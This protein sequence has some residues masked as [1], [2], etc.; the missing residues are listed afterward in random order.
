M[1]INKSQALRFEINKVQNS[2]EFR[3]IERYI[4]DFIKTYSFFSLDRNEAILS[5]LAQFEL[6]RRGSSIFS[7]RDSQLRGVDS[8]H[9]ISSRNTLFSMAL[10]RALNFVFDL[11]SSEELPITN[12]LYLN[13]FSDYKKIIK[14]PEI[15]ILMTEYV[16]FEYGC[17]MYSRGY[18]DISIQ[19]NNVKFVPK[20]TDFYNAISF[21]SLRYNTQIEKSTFDHAFEK[22]L[23]LQSENSNVINKINKILHYWLHKTGFL[24]L[25]FRIPDSNIPALIS[26][27]CGAIESYK[28]ISIN[29]NL[30]K[31]SL[32]DFRKFWFYLDI[33]CSLIIYYLDPLIWE[34]IQYPL[35]YIQTIDDWIKELCQGA[36]LKPSIVSDLIEDLTFNPSLKN[37]GVRVQPFVPINNKYLALTP[38]LITIY[39]IEGNF[40]HLQCKINKDQYDGL[41]NQKESILLDDITSVLNKRDDFV[42]K[43]KIVIKD[44][45]KTLTDIDL[46]FY[47]KT[48][49][50]L[51][52]VQA[53]WPRRVNSV[54]DLFEKD[55][56]IEE[57]I[58]QAKTSYKYIK[59]NLEKF[60]KSHF[61]NISYTDIRY[62]F[63]CVISRDNIG[64]TSKHLKE[65]PMIDFDIFK[66][67]LI[68]EKTSFKDIF[69][70]F[71]KRD[72]LPKLNVDYRVV[73]QTHKIGEYSFSVPGAEII[74][75]ESKNAKNI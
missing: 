3:K 56:E 34:S 37:V 67:Y 58:S 59:K 26:G 8:K 11:C 23:K 47:E 51:V 53:K 25:S 19:Q 43:K 6:V 2:K 45:Q 30:G 75:I 48:T 55:S 4:D 62:I 52:L 5:L 50:S 61:G 41:S 63:S 13:L 10:N 40:L 9:Q 60:L 27:A 70:R 1:I 29:W 46:A 21:E 73:F 57:G 18:F 68:K 71:S 22:Y 49:G 64:S 38:S 72:Y 69:P 36:D 12:K 42:Y 14:D 39:S 54:L 44:N 16:M 66:E 15:L 20:S 7:K 35:F 28:R 33:K 31:Y 17:K 32:E 24:P 65:F 74:E